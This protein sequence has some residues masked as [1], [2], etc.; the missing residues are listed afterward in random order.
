MSK[1]DL[2]KQTSK[3]NVGEPEHGEEL[4]DILIR[5]VDTLISRDMSGN[6]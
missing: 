1:V 2:Q 6:K 4:S 3:T 5:K